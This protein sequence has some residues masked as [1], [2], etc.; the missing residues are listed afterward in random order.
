MRR[1]EGRGARDAPRAGRSPNRGVT[2]IEMLVVLTLL[3]VMFGVAG[4]AA[5]SLRSPPESVW[6]GELR[7]A[8]TEAIRRGHR[9]R[10]SPRGGATLSP[11]PAP[12]AFLP[13]G[14]ALGPGVDPLT[15]IPR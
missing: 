7:R 3:G 14:R 6:A 11:L 12:V 4:V 15:G 2:L 8:R 9:V 5:S 1:G 13:D 10:A